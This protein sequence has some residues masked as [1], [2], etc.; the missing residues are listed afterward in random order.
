MGYTLPVLTSQGHLWN[1]QVCSE[2]TDTQS[3]K[4]C[5]ILDGTRYKEWIL[6]KIWTLFGI[7]NDPF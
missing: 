4:G 1:M 5:G 7:Q 3:L 6:R 2:D